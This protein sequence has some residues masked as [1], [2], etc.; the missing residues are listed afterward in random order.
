MKFWPLKTLKDNFCSQL[1]WGPQ[2]KFWRIESEA[3]YICKETLNLDFIIFSYQSCVMNKTTRLH[4]VQTHFYTMTEY[5]LQRG[6]F[7]SLQKKLFI[8]TID[9]IRQLCKSPA[10]WL[11]KSPG[12]LASGKAHLHSVF[13]ELITY[14]AE[15]QQ[16]TTTITWIAPES[17]DVYFS[18]NLPLRDH[19]MPYMLYGQHAI[20][21]SF[22]YI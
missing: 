8:Q 20:T 12:T 21:T 1:Y 15:K 3:L 22:T 19:I 16:A 14:E 2:L 7:I 9:K 10:S 5:I 6:Y 17:Q 18:H 4:T 11:L 13:S